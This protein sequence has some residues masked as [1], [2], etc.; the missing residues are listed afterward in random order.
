MKNKF[1][2]KDK[3]F[4][5]VFCNL[6]ILITLL[7]CFTV[8]TYKYSF[9][10]DEEN[11]VAVNERTDYVFLSDLDYITDNNWSYNGWGGHEIQKD[12]NQDGNTLSLIVDG[13]RR[14]FTKGVSIHG[15]GQATF[16]ISSLSADYPRFIA[17]IGVDAARG[18]NG[19]L[20]IQI[21][22][23]RDGKEWTS[24]LKTGNMSGV[25]NAV[26][27]DVS[28][29]GFKY[30]RIYVDPNGSNAADHGTI[31]N[32]R[33]VTNDFNKD[34]GFYDKI[35]KIEYY[36]E[37]LKNQSVEHNYQNNYRQ[38]LERE[39]V[40]KM[41]YWNI[42]DLAEHTSGIPE[43]LNWILSDNTILE[44]IIEV[45]E[46]SNALS[47]LNLLK[48]LYI[49]NKSA[50]GTQNGY[51]YQKMM[52]GLAAAY[53][54]D[55]VIS[56]L[57]F[58][59][60]ASSSYDPIERFNLMK[61]LFDNDKLMRVK[62]NA[63]AG[64]F[65]KNEWFKDYHVQLMRM[66]MQD[67]TTSNI[68]FFWL[69]GYTREKQS[70]SFYMIPYYSPNYNQAKLYDEANR[71]LY[72]EKYFLSKYNVPYGDRVQRY[73]MVIEAGGIC[74]NASRFAQSM[75]RVNG[76][77]STGAYQPGHELYIHYYQDDNGNG[78]WTPR[79]GNWGNAGS[80]WGGSNRY[81]YIF[82][83]GNKYFTD[84]NI[85]GP[86][87]GT[88]TGYIYLAQENLN[89]YDIYK[90]SLYYNLIA[91][92]YEDNRQK[93]DTYFKSL[94]IN[95]K[96]LDTY[97]Y[98]V[99]LYKGMSVKNEGG[100]ITSSDWH[101]L[102]SKIVDSYTYYPVAM[103]DLLKV[104]RPY[105]DGAERLDVDRLEKEA[106]TLATTATADKTNSLDGTR[107]HARQ[108]LGK[109]QP[110]PVSFSFDGENA[111]KIVKNPNYSLAYGYSLDGGKTF[112]KQVV[113]DSITLSKEEIES[114]TAENDIIVNFMGL[115]Y[116][117]RIDITKG[118]V[119]SNLFPNDLENRVVGV[120]LDY[121]WRNSES[122]PWTSYKVASPD[123]TGDKTLYVR[124]SA[125]GTQLTSDSVTYTFTEDNQP[126]TRKYVSVSHLSIED[127]STE[128]TNNAGAA[129]YAIDGNYNT[130]W[131][132]AWNGTDTERFITIKLDKPRYVSAVEFVPAAGGNGRIYDGTIWGSYDGENWEKLSEKKN[133]TYPGQANSVQQAI[134]YTQNFEIN[135]P[136]EVQYVK[137]VADRTNGNWF[138]ARA[139][140][141]FQDI[142][143]NPR[144][145]AGIGYSTIEPTTE[146]VVAR[147]V[148]IST[149]KYEILS[150]G[151]DTHTFT[152]NG[153]FTFR[154]RDTETGVEG[155]AKAVVN[156]IDR[157]APTATIEY[158]T[159]SPTINSVIATLRP[160][161]EVVVTNNGTYQIDD[162]GN[163]T[164]ADGNI[165]EG[166]TVDADGNVKN[167]SG[168][169]VGNLNT[170][171]YEFISNGE[172][173]FEFIDRA[174]NKGSAT[175]KVDWIDFEPPVATL[176]YNKL[177]LTNQDVTV[178]IDFNENA[179]V[180]NNNG[181]RT[182][183]FVD[184]GE[185]TFEFRDVAGNVG[186]I[187]AKVNW[188]DKI[189][190]TAELKYERQ[191]NK[192]I[193]RVV[194]PSEE[195]TFQEG[196]G[197]YEFTRNGS[198][199]IVFYDKA[200]NAS[201]LTA[202]IEGLDQN[203]GDNSG[204]LKPPISPGTSSKPTSKPN[205][206]TAKPTTKPTAGPSKPTTNPGGNNN[207]D[208]SGNT[209]TPIE[210]INKDYKKY[211][212]KNIR[213]EIPSDAIQGNVNLKVSS[214]ELDSSLTDKFGA[215]SEY[216][217]IHL[218]D[219][220]YA[221]VDLT[222]ESPMKISITLKKTMDFLG[223]YE[224]TKDNKMK[225]I[226][227]VRNGDTI[228]FVTNK[229]G[230]YVVSY[231]EPEVI[232]SE[233]SIPKK[234]KY[235]VILMIIIV[236]GMI[237]TI[238]DLIFYFLRKKARRNQQQDL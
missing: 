172:F 75:H 138:T 162:D 214:F 206:P 96:N 160:S 95:D 77:P 89:H 61:Q 57:S 73:W 60:K 56:P 51:V 229:L 179:T 122:D 80:T 69:N 106:L 91:N 157:V 109:A 159:L 120:T 85:G 175:A 58:S 41:G 7:F 119:S 219:S 82:D 110:D 22:V 187:T 94:E 213:V 161:E 48:D 113:D 190:P 44:Q 201:K 139:F 178:T 169:I 168:S 70:L 47:F 74:W 133:I 235:G 114:I 149:D 164:D 192:V 62:T 198:Y 204:D 4:R 99:S 148:N 66:V 39:F 2:L 163:I 232:Y 54:T 130:R 217:D 221:R 218:L 176:V 50:L 171:T 9:S 158:S 25:T 220:N 37:I 196:I 223:I 87:G 140:N 10:L 24:L 131:H 42:Q 11:I 183:T 55:G 76:I 38:V 19:D 186:N 238:I 209:D 194:N 101:S 84:Q 1:S 26:S 154:F 72:N 236:I 129:I 177:T 111:G 182:Y 184:N 45:G 23:S 151:G 107:T 83:W 31:A 234:S 20:W 97:D 147:L 142:T 105:L 102:A 18:K 233:E 170:F 5:K 81:R 188:V 32:A 135:V 35:H 173:T 30:L 174:G 79:Y 166:F 43:T 15:K 8:I 146:N 67:G 212:I 12:K 121:E 27:V 143:Q 205:K 78:Y 185:F 191:G 14:Y 59:F 36:D 216:F 207:G 165:I 112:S 181:S 117:F 13:E 71:E 226:D 108:L 227:Y 224:I 141:I 98:I 137:I 237:I 115:T 49:E 200:L 100:T 202:V 150:E 155:S 33:L 17:E 153:E 203:P 86:K 53:S 92:S 132:S 215:D 144:P 222:T 230:K 88:S 134:Q 180:T 40:R 103:F 90:K 225:D 68:D 64:E 21:L 3:T 123:N 29:E 125:T 231:E 127:V 128:A 199:D 104:I 6:S 46:I 118:S 193:V 211:F 34:I 63:L 136:K 28:I 52:I 145:T 208:G 126:N 124:K 167:E 16:D 189:P 210:P 228:E 116:T 195:I 152:E 197:V 65:V 93:L 156:W